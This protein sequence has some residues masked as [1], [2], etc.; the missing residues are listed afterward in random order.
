M[1][2]CEINSLIEAIGYQQSDCL[3][4]LLEELGKISKRA[5]DQGEA[6]AKET[7]NDHIAM[8]LQKGA[9]LAHKMVA[10]DSAL[11]WFRL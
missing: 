2:R 7:D 4:H 8:A 5:F 3:K 10:I 6:N 1:V 9:S 11:P